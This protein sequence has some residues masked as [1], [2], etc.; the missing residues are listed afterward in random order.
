[1]RASNPTF[2][3][4]VSN[5]IGQPIAANAEIKDIYS[6]RKRV[7]SNVALTAVGADRCV[8]TFTPMNTQSRANKH[9][10][11]LT[12]SFILTHTHTLSLSHSLSLTHS[13]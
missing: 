7:A 5:A 9:T 1:M 4:H 2:Q 6:G 3:I 10:H 8:H 11:T 12:H 13:H